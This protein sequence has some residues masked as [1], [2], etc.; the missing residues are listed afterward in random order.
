M[1]T[2]ARYNPA[3]GPPVHPGTCT[4]AIWNEYQQALGM[5]AQYQG[6][7]PKQP[8]AREKKMG[9]IKEFR[10]DKRE[11]AS[12]L[13][14]VEQYLLANEGVYS[15]DFSKIAFVLSQIDSSFTA[16]KWAE[17]WEANQ[18]AKHSNLGTYQDFKTTL[19]EKYGGVATKDQAWQVLLEG[20]YKQ[21]K[22][23]VDEYIGN[24]DILYRY[25]EIDDEYAKLIH[26]KRGLNEKL[27]EKVFITEN[28]PTT[29]AAACKATRKVTN[30]QDIHSGKTNIFKFISGSSGSGRRMEKDLTQWTLIGSPQKPIRNVLP[31]YDPA[32]DRSGKT[33][34]YAK[35]KTSNSRT[36]KYSG[37]GRRRKTSKLTKSY[38]KRTERKH[39]RVKR[40]EES[41]S[42]DNLEESEQE[43][44]ESSSSEES[45]SESSESEEV[46][47]QETV[48]HRVRRTRPVKTKTVRKIRRTK[49]ESSDSE[50]ESYVI[51]RFILKEELA[52]IQWED[53][54]KMRG[55]RIKKRNMTMPHL[56]DLLEFGDNSDKYEYARRYPPPMEKD[57]PES[58]EIGCTLGS[59]GI[60]IKKRSPRK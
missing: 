27:A 26:F 11:Y 32:P 13:R 53:A 6:A 52:R 47:E 7:I 16:G 43:E 20:K 33:T 2:H 39:R 41:D 58:F 17:S 57:D 34:S 9:K 23:T 10:G 5:Y 59:C 28:L 4:D 19:T 42:E 38:S 30:L 25:A 60:Q 36:K 37:S 49:D 1:A 24:L 21:D 22:Q 35:T 50:E 46:S 12:F 44:S 15:D 18:M 51:Q 31:E 56:D 55:D 45:E 54:L 48:V 29:Y 3:L 14:N 8:V 40:V